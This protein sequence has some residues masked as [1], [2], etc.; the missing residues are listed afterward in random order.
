[1][2]RGT[3]TVDELCAAVGWEA[4]G[5]IVE[6]ITRSRGDRRTKYKQKP[7]VFYVPSGKHKGKRP[8]QLTALELQQ[9]WS[10]YNGCGNTAV[11][12]E[13]LKEIKRRERATK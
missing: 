11:A 9:T 7:V 1:M 10:G 5:K 3:F 2:E 12:D 8:A 6:L 13:L 4:A